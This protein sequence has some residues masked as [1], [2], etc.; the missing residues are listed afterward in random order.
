MV[1]TVTGLK[2]GMPVSDMKILVILYVLPEIP[3]IGLNSLLLG[4]NTIHD[5]MKPDKISITDSFS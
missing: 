2:L 3:E 4:K 1:L 5:A